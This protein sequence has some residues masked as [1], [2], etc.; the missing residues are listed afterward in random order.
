VDVRHDANLL[1]QR[2]EKDELPVIRRQSQPVPFQLLRDIGEHGPHAIILGQGSL[3]CL[4]LDAGSER[5]RRNPPR[6]LLASGRAVQDDEGACHQKGISS[7]MAGLSAGR[8]ASNP[9]PYSPDAA[10]RSRALSSMTSV[11]LKPCSTIS[12]VNRSAPCWSV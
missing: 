1:L 7:L 4:E 2:V 10:G 6:G 11:E 5:S 12:V 3:G 8:C 9:A